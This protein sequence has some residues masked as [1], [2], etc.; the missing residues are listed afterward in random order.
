LP[1]RG[2]TLATVRFERGSGGVAGLSD[3]VH[4][5]NYGPCTSQ[6]KLLA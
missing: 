1:D 6:V 3:G 2:V 5:S 4:D